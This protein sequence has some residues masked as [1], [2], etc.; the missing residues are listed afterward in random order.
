MTTLF[1]TVYFALFSVLS[2]FGLHRYFITYLYAKNKG[3]K[4]EAAPFESIPENELPFVTVQLPIYNE[5]YV[6]PRLIE[7]VSRLEYPKDKLEIQVLDDSTDETTAI[8]RE[9]VERYQREGF[10]MVLIH[11]ENRSGYKA[12]ALNEGLSQMRGSLVAVF[13]A[14]FV[15]TAD[16]LKKTVPHFIGRPK[17]GMVQV[18]W[19]HLNRDF[20]LLTQTQSVFLDGHFMLE[21]TAR[22]RSGRFFNFNGT[23]GIW[24]REC[25]QSSGGWH[26]DTLTEDL[27][28]SYRAQLAGWQFIFLN[29]VVSP[30][31]LPVDLNAFKTQQH[32]WAKGSIQTARKLVP[33]IL[34]SKFPLKVKV[35]A[36]FHLCANFGYVCMLLVSILMP[37]SIYLRHHLHWGRL[38]IV[39]VPFFLSATFSVT[40]FYCY[41]QREIYADWLSRLKYLPFNLALGIGLSVNNSKAVIEALFSQR[42]EF[43]RTPKYAV[44]KK[45]DLWKG[46][47]YRGRLDFVSF[48]ELALAIHFT[49]A[50]LYAFQQKL[51]LSLPFLMIFQAGYAY[52]ALLSFYQ[53]EKFSHFLPLLRFSPQTTDK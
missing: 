1:L 7:A 16:F 46:K 12:G 8:V 38:F 31:E 14:D 37:F 4:P 32:R 52:T 20:S 23:A 36:L 27:D 49:I 13:D 53:S 2:I 24:Q 33:V 47:I 45:G 18:R 29:D 35:E 51:Y 40:F 22:N 26:C 17:I 3:R 39:D 44:I 48:V 11:R 43:T 34:K 28:L 50:V 6:A 42:G 25:I 15:P 41:S 30:A 10:Q 19:D 5:R 9:L 21:H